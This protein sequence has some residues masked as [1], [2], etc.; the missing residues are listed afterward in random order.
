MPPDVEDLFNRVISEMDNAYLAWQAAEAKRA[1]E[2][3]PPAEST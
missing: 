2:K 3:K 1:R